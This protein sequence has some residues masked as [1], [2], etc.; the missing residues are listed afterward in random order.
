MIQLLH[1]KESSLTKIVNQSEETL[2]DELKSSLWIDL[3]HP[4]QG[5][6]AL[7]ERSL[8][9][10]IPSL[11]EMEEISESSRLFTEGD[12]LYLSAWVLNFD[13]AIPV[14]SSVS[15]VIT[16]K[17]FITI[18]YSDH[19]AFRIF[20][21]T[22]KRLQPRRF[23]TTACALTELLEAIVGHIAS[24][25]RMIEQ[26]LNGLSVQIFSEQKAQKKRVNLKSIVQKLGKRNSLVAS[27]AESLVSFSTLIPYFTKNANS[28]IQPD[29]SDRLKTLKSDVKSLQE[30]GGQLSSEIAFLLDS[31][32][33]LISID[34][35]QSMKMLSI[36]AV[37]VA[38]I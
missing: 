21:N 29:L 35:N 8:A 11:E 33:G 12:V 26:D 23:T 34:Q 28:W 10:N 36:A 20:N 14:N 27:L 7:I 24:N 9:L 31:T 17:N 22:R 16:P 4:E 37:L 2:A 38:F 1:P 18:R 25:L 30:Y 3:M 6:E 5:E 13:S 19:H 15:F 32:V